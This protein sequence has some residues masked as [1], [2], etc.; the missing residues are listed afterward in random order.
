MPES[1]PKRVPTRR[2]LLVAMLVGVVS[3]LALVWLIPEAHHAMGP[4]TVGSGARLG[5]GTTR[6]VIPP[7][8]TISADTH[9]SLLDLDLVI[10]E[11]DPERLTEA[12]SS[13]GSRAQLVGEVEDDL[14]SVAMATALRLLLGG[15]IIGAIAAV[16]VSGRDFRLLAAGATGG[17]VAIVVT[18]GLTAAT[19]NV[20]AFEEPKFTGAL[21]RA[22]QVIAA[23]DESLSVLDG[24]RSRFESLAARL[25]QLIALVAEPVLAPQEESVAIL[26]VSDIHSNPIGIEITRTLAERFDVSA[27]LDTGDLT[28]FGEPIEARIGT[29]IDQIGVP[30]LYVP[31]NHDSLAN[32]A[33]IA[34]VDN[35]QL[36]DGL[37]VTIDGVRILGIP[38]PTFTATN[39]VATQEANEEKLT[40]APEVAE[41]VARTDPGV[42]AVHDARQASQSLGLVPLILAGHTH[43]RSFLQEAGSTLMVVGST[44]ATGLGSLLVEA[45]LR[46][47]AEILYFQDGEVVSYDYIS[48]DGLGGDF[49]I[50]RI[51]IDPPPAAEPR[52]TN[53]SGGE[54]I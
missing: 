39:E 32:R 17:A 8:G 46:Y 41:L 51:R 54:G 21:E 42:L 5:L 28:S 26:H 12:V 31:G 44:G 13:P 3:S 6:I 24:L 29:L 4:S 9:A 43:E 7:L 38:D 49:T 15:V 36:L 20:T 14:R 27:V 2:R 52:P 48:F 18:V 16:L 1:H 37:L 34:R 30:Y 25:S 11:V 19:F 53:S 47:E 22:P 45:D 23:V 50:E 35:V 40:L 33:E 10:G